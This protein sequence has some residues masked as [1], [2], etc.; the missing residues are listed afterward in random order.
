MTVGHGSPEQFRLEVSVDYTEAGTLVYSR[1]IVAKKQAF[2]G[3]ER[4]DYVGER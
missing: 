2:E 1:C 4:D 3:T